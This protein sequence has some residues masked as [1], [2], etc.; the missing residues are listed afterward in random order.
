MTQDTQWEMAVRLV[1]EVVVVGLWLFVGWGIAT[2]CR[3]V[4]E[5]WRD[6]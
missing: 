2:I 6:R 5:L 4:I 3:M 1:L